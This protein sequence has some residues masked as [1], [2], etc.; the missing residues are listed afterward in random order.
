M[1]AGSSIGPA[2]VASLVPALEK[3]PRL[4]LLNLA[5][6]RIGLDEA[7]AWEALAVWGAVLVCA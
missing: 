3:M 1:D 7:R 4:T 5:G 2:G 6:A